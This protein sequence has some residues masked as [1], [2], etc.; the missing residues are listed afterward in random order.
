MSRV[1]QWV[2]TRVYGVTRS[3]GRGTTARRRERRAVASF[4][5]EPQ[6]DPSR[7]L[8]PL[9][10][11]RPRHSGSRARDEHEEEHAHGPKSVTLLASMRSQICFSQKAADLIH[12]DSAIKSIK[13]S[14]RFVSEAELIQ[15]QEQKMLAEEQKM[16]EQDAGRD[17]AGSDQATSHLDAMRP[18]AGGGGQHEAAMRV[19][20]NEQAAA[21]LQQSGQ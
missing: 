8:A 1:W 6:H 19:K 15:Q 9:Q 18:V 5:G 2:G 21:F 13:Q 12:V 11:L 16:M 17:D 20:A 3:L 14:E 10:Q 4:S 7:P